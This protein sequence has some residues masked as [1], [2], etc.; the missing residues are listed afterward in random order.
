MMC[1][2]R[3]NPDVILRKYKEKILVKTVKKVE[4]LAQIPKRKRAAAYVR[5]SSGKDAMRHSMSA[6]ISYYSGY[7]QRRIEW[8]FAGIYVDEATTG[9]KDNRREFQRMLGDC[10]AGKIDVI[11]TKAVA[12]FARNTV[13]TLETLRE[14]K[15]LGIDVFFEKE[16]VHS[17]SGEGELMLTLLASYAQEESRNVSE[18]CKWRIRKMFREGRPTYTRLLGYKMADGKFSVVPEEAEIVRRIFADYLGGMGKIAIM[19]KLNADGVPTMR[20]GP[21]TMNAVGG[22]LCNTTYTGDLVLQKTFVAD[23]ISKAKKVNRG[24]FPIYHIENNHEAIIEREMFEAVQREIARRADLHKP[25]NPKT[26]PP[27]Y[28]FTGKVLCGSY[29]RHYQRKHVSA[30]T[31]YEKIVWICATFNTA[32]KAACDSQQIPEDVLLGKSAEALGSG[33]FDEGLF[34]ARIVEIRVPAHNTLNFVFKDGCTVEMEWQNPSRRHSWT[35]EMKQVARERQI[36]ILDE[37]RK[38]KI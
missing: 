2:A 16:N 8:E 32:G 36:R 37:R 19:K 24:E 14:L 4:R 11:I 35:E 31:K 23:H 13:T 33:S 12:R 25:T 6:Q 38:E 1:G 21:W 17:L 27:E 28:P 29:G 22:I 30:G 10:R 3:K 18:N 20:G 15:L 9:T 5:V 26:V 34:A 7:I